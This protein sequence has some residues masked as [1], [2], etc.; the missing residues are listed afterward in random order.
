MGCRFFIFY[1]N[2]TSTRHQVKTGLGHFFKNIIFDRSMSGL[3]VSLRVTKAKMKPHKGQCDWIA[4]LAQRTF[5]I[6]IREP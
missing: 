1:Q 3:H 4:V 6:I 2:D 5:L